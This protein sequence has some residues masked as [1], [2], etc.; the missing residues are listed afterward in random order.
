MA[1]DNYTPSKLEIATHAALPMVLML[2]IEMVLNFYAAPRNTIFISPYLLAFFVTSL[3]ALLVL[4]KGEIC[5]GQTNRL[6]FILPFLL[7]FAVGNFIYSIGFTPKYNPMAIASFA[8]ILSCLIY[9]RLPEDENLYNTLIYC[10]FGIVTI[11]IIQYLAI[12]WFELRSLFNGIRANNF[13]QVLL[14][15]LLAGWYLMLA[16]SRLEVFLKLLV[17]A[18]LIALILNYCW[19]AFVLYQYLQVMPEMSLLPFSLYFVAQF[20]IL[21]MLA[22]LLLGKNI[23]NPTAWT[24]STFLS[25]L[26]PF[27][28]VV[29]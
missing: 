17:K 4:W 12:Y 10:G 25:I 7:I 18:A 2:F 1:H 24:I 9:F 5:R 28:N 8:A 14:G 16:K 19:S 3:I 13:A 23:K 21:S 20:V 6:T 29:I 22:W 27:T 15:I 26:Y 11:G